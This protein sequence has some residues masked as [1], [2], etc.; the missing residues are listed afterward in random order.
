MRSLPEE[1]IHLLV[2]RTGWN[3]PY[4]REL[5][6]MIEFFIIKNVRI[7]E[8]VLVVRTITV[9][10]IVVSFI[11]AF[12]LFSISLL[13]FSLSLIKI[14]A[15]KGMRSISGKL[16]ILSKISCCICAGL[17]GSF[18]GLGLKP[19]YYTFIYL[20]VNIKALDCFFFLI[21]KSLLS[22]LLQGLWARIL[23]F[24]NLTRENCWAT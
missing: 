7:Q 1:Q 19:L 9:V 4:W 12:K 20:H 23:V 5:L 3:S 11:I 17:F 10:K 2:V 6:V 14:M 21:T 22:T 24:K 16:R 8:S 13:A 18:N 15:L